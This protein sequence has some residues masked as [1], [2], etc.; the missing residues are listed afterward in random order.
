MHSLPIPNRP[1]QSVRIDFMG[2]LP[3]S[4]NYDYLMVIIDWLTLHTHLIPTTMT[5]MAKDIAWL[6]LKEVLDFTESQTPLSQIE[7]Q[8]SQLS[9]GVNFRGSW[10]LN[11][12]CPQHSIHRQMELLNGP[13]AQS[14]KSFTPWSGMIKRIGQLN[15]QLLKLHSTATS[16]Q[17]QGSH[18]SSW[19][20]A[21]CHESTSPWP[22]TPHSRSIP[23]HA[24][25][26]LELDVHAQH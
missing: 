26:S 1:W 19:I 5:V 7:T 15:A 14:E 21:T 2:P 16:A 18:P 25:S 23:I 6:F 22:Q 4:T 20:M 10:G 12:L 11:S 8:N 24:T 13:I 3:K 17:Q 9:F